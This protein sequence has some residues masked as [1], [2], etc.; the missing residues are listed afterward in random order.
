MNSLERS[1]PDIVIFGNLKIG[2]GLGRCVE[3]LF[4][5]WSNY[6]LNI[7]FLGYRDAELL[8]PEKS[9]DFINF[10]HLGTHNKNWTIIR[11]WMHL[12]KT[13][14]RAVLARN[15][16]D[17]MLIATAGTMP[18]VKSRIVLEVRN[19]FVASAKLNSR[20]GRKKLKQIKRIYP[21]ADAL[22]APSQGLSQELK[23]AAGLNKLPIYSIPNTTIIPDI[24]RQAKE[25]VQHPWLEDKKEPVALSVARFAPQKNLSMLLEAF[26]KV[27]QFRNLRLIMLGDGPLKKKLQ[28]KIFELGIDDA[29]SMPGHVKNPYAWM[30]KADLLTLSSAWEG[31]PN[32]LI[33]ALAL[34]MQV[35]STDCP[36]GP[37]E[38][39]E[40]GRYGRLVPIGDVQSM[41]DA[42]CE[43]LDNPLEF[44]PS[45]AI[46]KYTA[47]NS[48]E[49]YLNVLLSYNV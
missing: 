16:I 38:I 42:I 8:G 31:S 22:I 48:A 44:T 1:C 36:S 19:N 9:L 15:H 27:R 6:R 30:A 17:N 49:T 5:V 21:R 41:A 40:N 35:V 39:L 11:L 32:V 25:Q 13:Q 3:N 43:T 33:E 7:Q 20:K 46:Q 24:Y 14:P 12:L 10:I 2:N 18:G 23:N 37:A 34:G 26:S 45:E 28:E 29:V 4:S 47:E